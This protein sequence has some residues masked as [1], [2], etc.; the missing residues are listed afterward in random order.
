ML[1]MCCCAADRFAFGGSTFFLYFLVDEL[2]FESCEEY[3][4]ADSARLRWSSVSVL[5]ESPVPGLDVCVRRCGGVATP[6][7][8]VATSDSVLEALTCLDTATAAP[9]G[10]GL[11]EPCPALASACS[12][13]AATIDATVAASRTIGFCGALAVWAGDGAGL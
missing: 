1:D 9:E 7:K 13:A 2:E 5:A 11:L 8:G 3:E 10:G 4:A 6:K 12:T